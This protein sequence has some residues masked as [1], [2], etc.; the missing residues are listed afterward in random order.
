[1]LVQSQ[2]LWKQRSPLG[3]AALLES[4]TLMK[5]EHGL[6]LLLHVSLGVEYQASLQE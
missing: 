1:M 4:E 2:L 5:R 3:V 6:R